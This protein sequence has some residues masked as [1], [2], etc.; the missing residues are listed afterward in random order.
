MTL[1]AEERLPAEIHAPGGTDL[2]APAGPTPLLV[3]TA[4]ALA[5]VAEHLADAARVAFDT[6]TTGTDPYAAEL[7]G[8]AVAWGLE[9]DRSAYIPLR[10]SDTPGLPWEIVRSASDAF[11]WQPK[12]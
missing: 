4:S 10:H 5:A 8:V 12:H 9:L 11:L 6:E 3:T 2:P 1:F 7:V